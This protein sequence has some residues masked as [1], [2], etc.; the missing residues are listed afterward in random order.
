MELPRAARRGRE[1]MS[2]VR[3]QGAAALRE[4][5]KR[6][7]L[8]QVELGDLIGDLPQRERSD[9]WFHY[10]PFDGTPDPVG[11]L[12]S[13]GDCFGWLDASFRMDEMNGAMQKRQKDAARFGQGWNM[14]S[15]SCVDKAK[16]ESELCGRLGVPVIRPLQ[17]RA[18]DFWIQNQGA[19]MDHL[20]FS[21]GGG[22]E[23]AY[24]QS[25]EKL[26]R[27]GMG[28]EQRYVWHR[29][30]ILSRIRTERWRASCIDVPDR[31]MKKRFRGQRVSN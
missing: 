4:D 5:E 21:A 17:A 3:K 1:K 9:R 18:E 6:Q 25:E 26:E 19:V 7:D 8:P 12:L 27:Y 14:A 30:G 28:P 11:F 20:Q 22:Y 23:E 15:E 16:A 24:S 10:G 2:A 31:R 13:D 29:S